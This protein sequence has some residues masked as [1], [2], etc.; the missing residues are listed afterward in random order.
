[1]RNRATTLYN[2]LLKQ[3]KGDIEFL[4]RMD[5]ATLANMTVP[6]VEG[7][8]DDLSAYR[9]MLNE[10]IGFVEGTSTTQTVVPKTILN[11]IRSF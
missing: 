1:M 11:K 6:D 9:T 4:A 5:A 2:T 10:L 8:Y 3:A 7:L